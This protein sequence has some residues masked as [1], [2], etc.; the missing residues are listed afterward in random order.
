MRIQGRITRW[1]DDKGFGF[2]RPSRGGPDVFVHISAFSSRS[3]RPIDYDLVTYRPTRDAKGRPQGGDVAFVGAAKGGTRDTKAVV[4]ALATVFFTAVF[5][6]D[7]AGA[8]S[9]RVFVLYV[10]ASVAAFGAY[11]IDKSAAKNDRWRTPESTLHLLSLMG[12][13]P[14]A[15]VAQKVFRHKSSKQSFQIVFWTTVVVNCGALL[16]MLSPVGA[17]ALAA[18]FGAKV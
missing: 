13:W 10:C 3:R 14:G 8:L 4:I 2:I 12:G 17:G 7:V 1:K 11:A 6:A 15:F 16:W 9:G 5:A 18:L